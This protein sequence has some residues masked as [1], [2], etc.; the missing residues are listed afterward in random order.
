[1]EENNTKRKIDKKKV[2]IIA[3]IILILLAIVLGVTQ[4]WK[5]DAGGQQNG[6]VW[7]TNAEEG[8]LVQKSDEE[9]Q[10]ELNEKV[11]QGMINISMN[12]SP[13]FEDGKAKGNRDIKALQQKKAAILNAGERQI[14]I[15]A[16]A[17]TASMDVLK[18]DPVE[19]ELRRLKMET[20]VFQT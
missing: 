1:M 12:T 3:L 20:L 14:L 6:M 9:I 15:P 2:G 18:E 13:V 4:P 5:H 11:A 19:R 10:K 17:E 16:V 7:D 8:G